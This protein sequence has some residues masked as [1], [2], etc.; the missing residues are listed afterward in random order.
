MR[1]KGVN[2]PG[3]AAKPSK[4]RR[5]IDTASPSFKAALAKCRSILTAL[6]AQPA[7]AG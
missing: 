3:P 5:P 7:G 2:I 6:R 1:Q 4:T